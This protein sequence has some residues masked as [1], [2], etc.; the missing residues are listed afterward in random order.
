MER[1][2]N[3]GEE[4]L[5]LTNFGRKTWDV[6]EEHEKFVAHRRGEIVEAGEE[7]HHYRLCEEDQAEE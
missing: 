2:F 3:E 1:T 7:R 4:Y 6:G 5:E